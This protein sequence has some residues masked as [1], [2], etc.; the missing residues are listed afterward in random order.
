MKHDMKTDQKMG[1]GVNGSGDHFP[2]LIV[3]GEVRG[4][5]APRR[6]GNRAAV[7]LR[8]RSGM[9]DAAGHPVRG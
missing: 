7:C 5:E 2:D 4:A 1:K 9:R 3:V 8:T 6:T